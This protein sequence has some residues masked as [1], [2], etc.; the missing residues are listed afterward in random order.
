[1]SGSDKKFTRYPFF[2]PDQPDDIAMWQLR[3]EHSD[4][5][6]FGDGRSKQI[7]YQRPCRLG[8]NDWH[9]AVDGKPERELAD[10]CLYRL[11]VLRRAIQTPDGGARL[12]AVWTEGEK[13]ADIIADVLA[14][15]DL[16]LV[17][18]NYNQFGR[19]ISET[20]EGVAVSH[21]GGAL[22]ATPQQ[23]EHFR[24]FRGRVLVAVDW[25][26]AGAACGLRRYG[27]LRRVGL[28]HSQLRLVR[29]ANGALAYPALPSLRA[30]GGGGRGPVE[31]SGADR[32]ALEELATEQNLSGKPSGGAD[33]ADHVAAG[34][35]LR[36]LVRVRRAELR[37]AAGRALA[38]VADGWVYGAPDGELHGVD[39][40][41]NRQP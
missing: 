26:D 17:T 10:R 23:A 5:R 8:N 38:A 28:Q 33:L 7:W 16:G 32:F 19:C 12:T 13:D 27:L 20:T 39:W 6:L 40:V 11:Q 35:G 34:Y 30:T 36:D 25:D 18:L 3:M 31:L 14:W 41:R 4:G 22:K 29:A 37:A 24:G 2:H 9:L 21:H 15:N 1:M